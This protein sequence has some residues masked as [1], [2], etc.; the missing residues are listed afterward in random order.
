MHTWSLRLYLKLSIMRYASYTENLLLS[1][2]ILHK[3]GRI[4]HLETFKN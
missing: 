1:S 2:P 3:E 4:Q